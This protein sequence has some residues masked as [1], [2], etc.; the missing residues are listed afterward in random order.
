MKWV[1]KKK[2]LSLYHTQIKQ[3]FTNTNNF[4]NQKKDKRIKTTQSNMFIE[5]VAKLSFTSKY[6]QREKKKSQD[7]IFK[8][9]TIYIKIKLA[10]F[11]N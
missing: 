3:S 5:A 6:T 11:T 7:N 8:C 9:Y 2:C 10:E 1:T 4:H